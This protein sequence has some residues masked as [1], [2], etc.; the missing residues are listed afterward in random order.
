[1][2]FH[3][4]TEVN[5]TDHLVRAVRC[6]KPIKHDNKPLD[7]SFCIAKLKPV[8]IE[9]IWLIFSK[10]FYIETKIGPSEKWIKKD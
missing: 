4:E 7:T 8:P 9:L 10:F 2:K 3:E 1:L 5:F 6:P